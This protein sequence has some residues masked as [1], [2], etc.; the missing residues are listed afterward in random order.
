MLSHFSGNK[1]SQPHVVATCNAER[2]KTPAYLDWVDP[3]PAIYFTRARV[4]MLVGIRA[5][6]YSQ[7][8]LPKLVVAVGVSRYG[9]GSRQSQTG[10]DKNRPKV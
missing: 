8:Y 6:D 9:Q 10:T 1:Q 2:C 5:A 3:G 7:G 4:P